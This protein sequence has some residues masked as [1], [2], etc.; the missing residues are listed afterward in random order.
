[1]PYFVISAHQTDSL[2]HRQPHPSNRSTILSMREQLYNWMKPAGAQE[3]CWGDSESQP[4]E[5]TQ[6][7]PLYPGNSRL[8]H[9]L[10]LRSGPLLRRIRNCCTPVV[11]K[12]HALWDITPRS[13]LN[14]G[15]HF[16]EAC[17]LYLY[18]TPVKTLLVTC[19]HADFLLGLLFDPEDG[20][21][22][23]LRNVL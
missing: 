17:R 10:P 13:P 1:M 6:V 14:V 8:S 19:F 23:V 11:M 16:G 22:M 3:M 2:A 15:R 12:S 20:G 9:D 4:P 18:D 21:N 7:E 5:T